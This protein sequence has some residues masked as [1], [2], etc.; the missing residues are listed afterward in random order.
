MWLGLFLQRVL[1]R[2][3]N[4]YSFKEYLFRCGRLLQRMVVDRVY[5]KEWV[6]TPFIPKHSSCGKRK[7]F[8]RLDLNQ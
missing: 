3:L 5:V 8:N 7:T 6:L 2:I 1:K 4:K